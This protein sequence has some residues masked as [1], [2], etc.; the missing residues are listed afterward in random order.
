MKCIYVAI[1]QKQSTVA[2]VVDKA[3]A[4]PARWSTPSSSPPPPPS[5]R[6]SSSSPLHRRH[7]RRVLARQRRPRLIIYDDLS[8]QAV[9]Y[10][11][12]S[13]LLPAGRRRTRATS[14]TSSRA[15]RAR[16][17]AVRRRGAGSTALPIIETRAG[18]VSAYIPTNVISSPTAGI[19]RADLFFSTA[20]ARP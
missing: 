7:H 4:R 16:R 18:D 12:L 1:G 9:A 10:R 20:S 17:Q 11:Q 2:S 13:L 6:R 5:R 19:P 14:S 3:P 8:K 15:C